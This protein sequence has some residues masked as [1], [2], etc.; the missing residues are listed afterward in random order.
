MAIF[1][2][3]VQA[4]S[5]FSST[6]SWRLLPRLRIFLDQLRLAVPSRGPSDL[7][8][9]ALLRSSRG[10]NQ[11]FCLVTSILR[12]RHIDAL[13]FGV[14]VNTLYVGDTSRAITYML[15]AIRQCGVLGFPCRTSTSPPTKLTSGG[16][17]H[18]DIREAKVKCQ[19]RSN[20]ESPSRGRGSPPAARRSP[21]EDICQP[22]RA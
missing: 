15:C 22:P 21:S 14:L 18:P 20:C 19:P 4:P 11:N 12:L 1:C 9:L 2:D 16:R 6:T 13:I 17:D 7:Q 10:T 3:E 8:P 5:D